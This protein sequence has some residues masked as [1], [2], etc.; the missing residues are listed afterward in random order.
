MNVCE[1]HSNLL[2]IMVDQFRYDCLG[3]LGLYP[4][5]TPHLDRLA[6][7]GMHLSQA[8]T[9][10]PTCCP[11]RQSFMTGQRAEQ[12]GALWN[13]DITLP[14]ASMT[15]DIP[16]WS[17]KLASNGYRCG[18]F[19]KWHC[20]QVYNPTAFGFER[21][22]GEHDYEAYLQGHGY[23][24]STSEFDWKGG[25]SQI[26]LEHTRTHVL[27]RETISWIRECHE[28]GSAWAACLEFPEPHLPC[29]PSQEFAS[30]YTA[31]DAVMWPGFPD[32]LQNKPPM[33]RRQWEN[34]NVADMTWDDW[35]PIV[36]RYYAIISQLD[37]AIGRV[38]DFLDSSGQAHN[39]L[40]VFTSDH[41]DLCGSH[42]MPD[43]HYV[44]YDDVMRV[45]L[46]MRFP[47]RIPAGSTQ[48]GFVSHTIDLPATMMELLG[49]PMDGSL[50][51][52][53][54]T[55]WFESGDSHPPIRDCITGTYHGAQF[56]LYCQRMLRTE[57]YAYIWN[58]TSFEELYDLQQD[59]GQLCNLAGNPEMITIKRKLSTKLYDELIAN[60]DPLLRE[61]WIAY[62]LTG[63][64]NTITINATV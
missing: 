43:K 5:S 51:G 37:D 59:Q 61:P 26:P 19:G 33:Q 16:T 14:V 56:G 64:R 20:S 28:A 50:P 15:P 32:T 44:M 25:A 46:I 17:S 13:Y 49:K 29:N 7:E 11:A 2:V 42:G 39:T 52:K 24:P 45:P 8:Y 53:S 4:I 62:Q 55:Q 27:A 23:A 10:V 41:G 57:Q 47:G 58:P 60:G 35:A 21:Y 34:W 12:I 38:L 48:D 54:F 63:K 31:A 40:V 30:R 6:K 22:F 36:A 9:T 18:Y 1:K 3:F